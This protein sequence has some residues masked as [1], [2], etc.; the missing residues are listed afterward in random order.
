M[1]TAISIARSYVKDHEIDVSGQFLSRV[2]SFHD[3]YHPE[4]TGWRLTWI[5]ADAVTLDGEWSI[6]VYDDGRVTADE[7]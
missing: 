5:P 1:D 3:V 6:Y 2:V 4:N 7:E